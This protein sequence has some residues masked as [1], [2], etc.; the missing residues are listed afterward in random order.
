MTPSSLYVLEHL[1]HALDMHVHA[2]PDIINRICDDVDMARAVMATG[3][4][5]AVIKN[6]YG[7]T[8]Q[9]ALDVNRLAGKAVL[10]GSLTLNHYVGGFNPYAV[11]AA[12]G[13][14]ARVIWFPT[15]HAENHTRQKLRAG[16]DFNASIPLRQA[17][18]LRAVGK[19]GELTEQ[20]IDI[21]ELIASKDACLC[22]GH[23]SN[24]EALAVC[25]EAL[26][27]GVRRIVLTH[28]DFTLNRLPV[29]TQIH[30]A[31]QG[32]YIEKTLFTASAGIVSAAELLIGARKAG[33]HRCFL[34][35]DYG[36]VTKPAPWKGM[37][38]WVSLAAENGFSEQETALLV[39]RVPRFLVGL[40]DDPPSP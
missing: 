38:Q 36:M 34:S 29:E 7:G 11:E 27:R 8:T 3:M 6:H 2:A 14:G 15:R 40:D 4:D 35:S 28:P 26:R 5:G 19:N 9:G 16:C 17:Q 25:G 13:L 10:F 32:V 18:G 22:T 39:S 24:E 1:H 30:L 37:A 33:L 23:I 20:V 12:L 31:R 21:I